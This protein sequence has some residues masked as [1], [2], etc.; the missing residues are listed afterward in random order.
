M[1]RNTRAKELLEEY[2]FDFQF[3]DDEGVLK[4]YLKYNVPESLRAQWKREWY[5]K[6]KSEF[7]RKL[8]AGRPARHEFLNIRA[9]WQYLD[10]DTL[11][12]V[13]AT[14][15]RNAEKIGKKEALVYLRNLA[16]TISVPS[17][18]E[19]LSEEQRLA[20]SDAIREAIEKIEAMPDVK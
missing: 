9:W 5:E 8:D 11:S 1:K 7:R 12:L 2:D 17:R 3:M 13:T 14:T 20:A 19:H 18:V 6:M 15:A 4:K 16:D 10:P